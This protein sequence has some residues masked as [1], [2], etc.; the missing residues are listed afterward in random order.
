MFLLPLT[1]LVTMTVFHEIAKMHL[2]AQYAY[3]IGLYDTDDEID[4]V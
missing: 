3:K 1:L 2:V 4:Y